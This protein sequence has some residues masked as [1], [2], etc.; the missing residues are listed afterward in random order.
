MIKEAAP[1]NASKAVGNR[2]G[3]SGPFSA[4]QAGPAVNKKPNMYIGKNV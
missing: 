1:A 4:S 3:A 2:A